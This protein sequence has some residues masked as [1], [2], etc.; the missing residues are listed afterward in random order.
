VLHG[1]ERLVKQTLINLLSNA[2]KFTQNGGT[3]RLQATAAAGGGL[4]VSVTD[5][6]IG[7]REED[8][9]RALA[10]FGQVDS[11]LAREYEGTGLGLPLAKSF[12]ELHGGSLEIESR[13]GIGTTVIVRFPAERVREI[14]QPASQKRL[15]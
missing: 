9:P 11:S 14:G 5:T 3:V 6:G 7:M 4:T 1:D 10:P 8:I 15:A 2:V 12:V 13:P